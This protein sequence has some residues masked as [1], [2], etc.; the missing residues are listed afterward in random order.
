MDFISETKF[1]APIKGCLSSTQGNDK[2]DLRIN[3][4]LALL[5]N[6]CE[7]GSFSITNDICV[8][9]GIFVGTEMCNVR[10]GGVKGCSAHYGLVSGRTADFDNGVF[11]NLV[12]DGGADEG[13][14]TIIGGRGNANVK[15]RLAEFQELNVCQ[16]T[17]YGICSFNELAVYD[18]IRFTQQGLYDQCYWTFGYSVN[19]C[20][21]STGED[22]D[23]KLIG[24]G[25]TRLFIDSKCNGVFIDDLRIGRD[26]NGGPDYGITLNNEKITSWSDLTK[27]V[28][29]GT[30][31]NNKIQRFTSPALP[32]NCSMFYFEGDETVTGTELPFIQV[33]ETASGKLFQMDVW[34]NL[35]EACGAFT[36]GKPVA[37]VEPCTS[38]IEAGKW[39]A[40]VMN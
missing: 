1:N 8:G 3:S 2:G 30:E 32:A 35:D 6:L 4:N 31:T 38:A 5:G 23:L 29:G 15:G 7:D 11:D 27:Y 19:N 28:G 10:I 37:E 17:L 39:T 33:R 9:Y 18:E 16:A 25:T 13:G 24:G 40:I 12:V 21:V 20:E 14:V 36:L 22:S 26:D 34:V